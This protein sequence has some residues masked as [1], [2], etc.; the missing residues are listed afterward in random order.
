MKNYFV[1]IYDEQH[2]EVVVQKGLDGM[3]SQLLGFYAHIDPERRQDLYLLMQKEKQLLSDNEQSDFEH[4]LLYLNQGSAIALTLDQLARLYRG[5]LAYWSW[6]GYLIL[7]VD[8]FCLFPPS[9]VLQIDPEGMILNELDDFI[10]EGEIG[11]G[12]LLEAI[13][14]KQHLS[15]QIRSVVEMN[16]LRL[17]AL[18]LSQPIV[19]A[20]KRRHVYSL[21]NLF[22]LSDRELSRI[23]HLGQAGRQTLHVQI[24]KW[25]NA[26]RG[27]LLKEMVVEITQED[28]T[29]SC[30][31]EWKA[32]NTNTLA[33][34]LFEEVFGQREDPL[35]K[36]KRAMF[37]EDW[38]LFF[39]SQGY[40]CLSDLYADRNLLS[41]KLHDDKGELTRTLDLNCTSLWISEEL[42]ID[43][44]K[45][46]EI[47]LTE[48]MQ[49]LETEKETVTML[50][51]KMQRDDP[52]WIDLSVLQEHLPSMTLHLL[53]LL[54]IRSVQQGVS[55]YLPLEDYYR[56]IEQMETRDEKII[57]ALYADPCL[58]DQ[59]ALAAYVDMVFKPVDP[60]KIH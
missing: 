4:W 50:L 13:C 60:T 1:K 17:E 59:K 5:F 56:K 43:L 11:K 2:W 22:S 45:H 54:L 39:L 29:R 46:P 38:T 20:L 26:L 42:A 53:H 48:I 34:Q 28:Q 15:M 30:L 58:K 49:R 8:E 33:K 14:E 36:Q 35:Y 12:T 6:S 16:D 31:L 24:E 3:F 10:K 21:T 44:M 51:E 25:Q 47:S 23:P 57:N 27:E 41:D 18:L 52:R 7:K 55:F 32:G 37:P 9:Y 40:L 19:K